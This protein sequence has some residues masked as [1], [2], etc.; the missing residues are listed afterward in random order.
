[1][2]QKFGDGFYGNVRFGS[3]KPEEKKVIPQQEFTPVQPDIAPPRVAEEI[4][5]RLHM[6]L[7]SWGQR[8]ILYQHQDDKTSITRDLDF[9]PATIP[10]TSV[11]WERGD[12]KQ[13]TANHPNIRKITVSVDDALL[14]QVNNEDDLTGSFS[15]YA[16]EELDKS[17]ISLIFS[18]NFSP[19]GKIVKTEYKTVCVC[20]D[21]N[22][23]Q[24]S[25]PNCPICFGLNTE[26][27]Y[28][29]Y[30]NRRYKDGLI[31]IRKQHSPKARSLEQ[32]GYTAKSPPQFR[33]EA[34]PRM[35]DKDI[36]EIVAG[37]FAGIRYFVINVELHYIGEKAT[38]QTFNT[39]EITETDPI[40][41]ALNLLNS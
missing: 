27:G 4:G 23:D 37:D 26:E 30:F 33:S 22:A 28:K 13:A 17:K 8:C 24:S 31:V 36:I 34:T 39:Q 7:G 25:D 21:L 10:F 41:K 5:R 18:P 29:R 2:P 20:V 14:S 40:Y 38:S 3:S 15:F 16:K 9:L 19:N 12:K 32:Y 11:I 35:K 6:A 1:M